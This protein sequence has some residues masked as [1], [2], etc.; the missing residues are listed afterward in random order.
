MDSPSRLAQLGYTLLG[1]YSNSNIKCNLQDTEGY[2]YFCSAKHI[3]AGHSP[4][5]FGRS[6]PFTI[7]NIRLWLV[8]NDKPFVLVTDNYTGAHNHLIFHC[9]KCNKDFEASW[10]HIHNGNGCRHCKYDAHRDV[11]RSIATKHGMLFE[12]YPFLE[13]EWDYE[14]KSR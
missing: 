8:L 5:K 4:A 13:K 10:N 2:K 7:H 9:L 12:E 6:N 1:E 3:F 14:K 11:L